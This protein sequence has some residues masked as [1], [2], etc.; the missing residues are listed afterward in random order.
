MDRQGP[1]CIEGIMFCS[2]QGCVSPVGA[3]GHEESASR[4]PSSAVALYRE[5]IASMR[6]LLFDRTLFSGPE[7]SK[8]FVLFPVDTAV[9]I[10]A[11]RYVSRR[12]TSVLSAAFLMDVGG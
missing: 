12:T 5:F 8:C 7:V 6:P 1:G 3:Q 2:G 10:D 4:H 11:L 9:V